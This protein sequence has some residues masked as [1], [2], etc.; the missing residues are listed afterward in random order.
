MTAR[1]I[2]TLILALVTLASLGTPPGAAHALTLVSGNQSGVWDAAGS[3]YI[4]TGSVTVPV[5]QTLTI[6][7]AVA[8][9]STAGATIS[10]F[11][12]LIAT[13]TPSQPVTFTSRSDSAGGNP[14]PGHW[15]GL[16]AQSGST[17]T[18]ENTL[19]RYGGGGGWGNLATSV[20][21]A[22]SITWT[23]G[24]C[25]ASAANGIR[26]NAVNI[27]LSNLFVTG[28]AGDGVALDSAVPATLS[29]IDCDQNGAAAF[30]V[31]AGAGS[32]PTTLTGSSNGTNGIVVGGLLGGSAPDQTWRWDLNPGLAYVI[33]GAFNVANND[34]LELA[35]ARIKLGAPGAYLQVSGAG[36]HL[37]AIPDTFGNL[38]YIT[39]LK[40]DAVGG[41]TNG[42][43]SATSP[44][45][46][47]WQAVYINSGCT[48]DLTKLTLRYGGS[49]SQANLMTNGA[50]AA[51]F[52]CD[53]LTSEFSANDGVRVSCVDA[54]VSRFG[55]NDDAADGFEITPTNP[56]VFVAPCVASRNGGYA[57]RVTQNPGSF[58]EV[59]VIAGTG[60][61]VNGIYVAGTL[62]GAAP[63]QKSKWGAGG[64][65]Y[66]I[67]TL[68]VTGSD[69]L[70]IDDVA[71]VKFAGAGS[72]LQVNGAGAH[73]RTLGFDG[74][75]VRFTSLKDDNIGGDTNN[76]GAATAPA[77]GDWQAIL[78][79]GAAT[80]DLNWTELHYGGSGGGANMW[81]T[82]GVAGL[83]SW[84]GG[85]TYNSASDGVRAS[86]VNSWFSSLF[87]NGN[88]GDG[89]AVTPT[90]PPVFNQISA[91]NNTG[92]GIR[93]NQNAGSFPGNITGSNNGVN[94]IYL[95]GALGGSAPNQKWTWGANPTFPYF[96]SG[97]VTCNGPDSLEIAAGA[98]VKFNAAS[99][100]YIL[101]AG[102]HLR[103]LGTSDNPVWFTSRKDDSQGGDTNNDGSASTA[104]P[105]D[106]VGLSLGNEARANLAETWIAYGGGSALANVLVLSGSASLA[107]SGGG[108]I[109]SA[110]QGISG[111]F[112]AFALDRVRVAENVTTGIRLSPSTGATAN[113]CDIYDNDNAGLS[114]GF[115]N[116][117]TSVTIDATSSWWGDATGPFDPSPGPPSIN[118]GGLGERVSDY[119]NY[120][121]WLSAPNT[122]QPPN[123]FALL[124]PANGAEE[125]PTS[126]VFVWRSTQDPEGGA[127]TYDLVVDDDPAFG[128][129]IA[130]ATGLTDTTYAA[131]NI[132]VLSTPIY[133]KVIARDGAGGAR[134]GAP[135]PSVFTIPPATGV[136][137][138]AEESAA[139]LALAVSAPHPNPFRDSSTFAF[140]LPDAG[141]VRVDIF[142][143]SGRLVHTLAD[144]AMPRGAHA[145]VWEGRNG[146]GRAV[147]AGV[148]FYRLV[149]TAETFTRRTVLAR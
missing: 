107:W 2:S 85:G 106:W 35:G 148:Y 20:P 146:S 77:G 71:I 21:Q 91:S 83:V 8:V 76:N 10:V 22:T 102:A 82:S 117:L 63:A 97:T 4:V 137:A 108:T 47:D 119:V 41:D 14:Q 19:M 134:L 86:C 131:G 37:R 39:S 51:N 23:G 48:V 127:I 6:M 104:A 96:L 36:A 105:G 1:L 57:V 114:Y 13:G 79:N 132:F 129:P 145:V 55:A 26:I 103:T 80:V 116:N 130:S 147:G 56:P 142:D 110:A 113:N 122:N 120:G 30:R 94:G 126:I 24:S 143:V 5:G 125:L 139:P 72:W 65:P 40:D 3:P 75:P 70:E 135:T 44:A 98:V 33:T 29:A 7:P 45:P 25:D 73:L 133:W 54:T 59:F 144:G 31:T 38:P 123:G 50:P 46:G 99:Y 28:N 68:N 112:T 100:L 16:F 140:T 121:S 78:V 118:A 101:G 60:N 109:R 9:K 42:D 34:T 84:N 149:T 61:G 69:T 43:G 64:L 27:S 88:A 95:N 49:G 58:P 67:G 90:L 115:Y 17:V 11:G 52:T 18:L 141:P 66:V 81:T 138:P 15:A 32:F 87:A 74:A 89:I 92:Y 124:Q 136:D 93:V 62:G 128:S 53:L 12:T 111:A